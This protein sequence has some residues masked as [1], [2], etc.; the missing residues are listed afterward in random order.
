MLHNVTVQ[1]AAYILQILQNQL[2]KRVQ[3]KDLVRPI[4]DDIEAQE[5]RL[6]EIYETV[7]YT[8]P[9]LEKSIATRSQ[10]QLS[11]S[12]MLGSRTQLGAASRTHLTPTVSPCCNLQQPCIGSLILGLLIIIL[13]VCLLL[14]LCECI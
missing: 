2:E 1:S 12:G 8:P 5:K 4:P 6:Q 13:C 10:V 14:Q 11:A 9:H 7:G 3:I